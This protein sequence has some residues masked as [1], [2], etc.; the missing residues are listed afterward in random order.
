[1]RRQSPQYV[2]LLP[3]SSRHVAL[4]A[5]VSL[6]ASQTPTNDRDADEEDDE[7]DDDEDEGDDDDDDD[8]EEAAYRGRDAHHA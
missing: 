6:G 5:V 1:M 3:Q 4:T 2:C 7:A 8:D